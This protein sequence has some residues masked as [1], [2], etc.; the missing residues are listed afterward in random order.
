LSLPRNIIC[1]ASLMCANLARLE[2]DLRALENAGCEEVHFDIMDGLFVPNFTM[3]PDFVKMARRCCSMPCSAHLMIS[4]PDSYIQRF[5]EAGC[6]A[7]TVHVEACK[8][9]H[10]TLA[11]IRSLGASPGIAI[12]PATPLIKLDYLLE[13]AD[14]VLVMTV[15][16]GYAGQTILPG[17]YDRV[18]ILRENINYRELSAKIEVD[19]NINVQNAAM[20]SRAGADIFDL[21]SSSIF[22]GGDLAAALNDFRAAV[23]QELQRV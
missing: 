23:A 5:V 13:L 7:V 22:K 9:P 21:G 16:P 20:L 3:G 17:A 2:D 19:G 6:S 12:N 10:R 8:H 11:Q 18:R 15:D 1:S 4:R 14:R